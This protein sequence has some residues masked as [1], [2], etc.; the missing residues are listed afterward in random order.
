M[1]FAL[2]LWNRVKEK[3]GTQPIPEDQSELILIHCLEKDNNPFDRMPNETQQQELFDSGFS[4]NALLDVLFCLDAQSTKKMF[5]HNRELKSAIDSFITFKKKN[6][7]KES[8]QVPVEENKF[9]QHRPVQ[10]ILTPEEEADILEAYMCRR[11]DDHNIIQSQTVVHGGQGNL[12]SNNVIGC[13]QSYN[14]INNGGAPMN[15][16]G[17]VST[18]QKIKTK[19]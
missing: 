13:Y 17:M 18:H 6:E 9:E 1:S 3:F 10:G 12:G 4:K 14:G 2:N 11:F 19:F 7:K 8:E 16:V 5:E 15:I